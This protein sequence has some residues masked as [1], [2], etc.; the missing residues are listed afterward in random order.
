MELQGRHITFL[1]DS[2]TFG[3]GASDDTHRFSTVLCER[4]G[5][6]EYN[7]GISGTTL[8]TDGERTSRLSHVDDIPASSDLI[9]VFLGTN[10]FD[11]CHKDECGTSYALGAL[12]TTDTTTI[13]GAADAYCRK[14]KR[15][16]GEKLPF[17]CF[18]SPLISGWN[19]SVA[20][21]VR[22]DFS[23]DKRNVCGY[24]V[25]QLGAAIGEVAAVHGFAYLPLHER[26]VLSSTEFK[27]GLHPNDVGMQ[28]IADALY[29]FLVQI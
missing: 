17:V 13:Y 22:D 26:V 10:D 29:D 11:A 8:C 24:S 21:D 25:P 4:A 23:T 12:G 16:F 5:A 28:K 3:V 1:G 14:I 20:P 19:R 6:I 15:I 27:D 7:M 18:V 2:I 9:I